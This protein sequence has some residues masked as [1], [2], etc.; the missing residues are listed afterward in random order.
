[1]RCA[2]TTGPRAVL[3]IAAALCAA[4]AV[5]AST[6][7]PAA[8]APTPPPAALAPW[9]HWRLDSSG[10][11]EDRRLLQT[12]DVYRRRI[13][14]AD[15]LAA[16]QQ[17][18]GVAVRAHEPQLQAQ[19]VTVYAKALPLN[20]LM[21]Q[22][23]E[24]LGLFWYE[25]PA[26]GGPTYVVTYGSNPPAA[27]AAD[28][29]SA[30]AAFQQ[31]RRADR[32]ADILRAGD[33]SGADL[34]KLAETDPLLAEAL[35]SSSAFHQHLIIETLKKMR[36]G[37]LRALIETG[38][39]TVDGSVLP[40]WYESRLR[41]EY[42]E[43]QEVLASIGVSSADDLVAR[44]RVR[45]FDGG[46]MLTDELERLRPVLGTLWS[47]INWVVGIEA[48]AGY[49]S[50]S[51]TAVIPGSDG[52]IPL[53]LQGDSGMWRSHDS[54]PGRA[55]NPE[56]VRQLLLQGPELGESYER[57]V[58]ALLAE[59]HALERESVQSSP[60]QER[61]PLAERPRFGLKPSMTVTQV[62]AAVSDQTGYA[63]L[64]TYF[65]GHDGALPRE[66]S[67]DE[68]IFVLLN[69]LAKA[70][71]CSWTLAGNVIIWHHDDWFLLEDD[72]ASPPR[73]T[74]SDEGAR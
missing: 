40:A 11:P 69:R 1:M 57:Q 72:A 56:A 43:S 55:S 67:A 31:R 19:Q 6:T 50:P 26:S 8:P 61:P 54:F 21:V 74:I 47:G 12:V 14:V 33:M 5:A 15:L 3:V 20:A 45:L 58:D 36:P 71:E 16:A 60:W 70:A 42:A 51:T 68:P 35:L 30:E 27:R 25:Q 41:A 66:A 48:P 28:H 64:G 29:R 62:L 52:L 39:T 38:T 46:N 2:C 32:I 53:A 18:T 59:A 7:S 24:L 44:F 9:E 49:Q 23:K 37:D 10:Y 65:A 63:M 73:A 22:L 4:L 17:Q 34:R 13:T